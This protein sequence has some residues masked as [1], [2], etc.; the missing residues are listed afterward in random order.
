MRYRVSIWL[1]GETFRSLVFEGVREKETGLDKLSFMS[2]GGRICRNRRAFSFDLG[3]TLGL[4]MNN[5]AAVA[6]PLEC[7][8]A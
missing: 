1:E 2:L 7:S 3:V 5:P 4:A 6:R 8:G